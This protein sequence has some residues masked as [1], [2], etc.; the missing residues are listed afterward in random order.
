MAIILQNSYAG[1]QWAVWKV[2]ESLEHLIA[3]SLD[4]ERLKSSLENIP[5]DKRKLEFAVTRLTLEY[6][7]GEYAQ[8]EYLPS[9]KPFLSD[10][11]YHISLTHT[12]GFV[13]AMIH[14]D[15][16]VGIDL[17]HV[18][19]RVMKIQQRFLSP[20]EISVLT[21][22]HEMMQTL[23]LWSAKESVFKALGEEGVDFREQL[24]SR[25]FE[26]HG[27]GVLSLQ[28][29]RTPQQH[30][31]SIPYFTNEDFVLTLTVKE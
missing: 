7:I 21:P 6:L 3:L 17:E 24:V 13:A 22:E 25:P 12:N 16:E 10:S 14:P 26:F 19:P 30:L 2:E 4:A 1:A 20:D 29:L 27:N 9:G 5:S 31:F 23:I 15:Q 28:E 18:S 11:S 8:V